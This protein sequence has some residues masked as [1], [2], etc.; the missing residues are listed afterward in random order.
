MQGNW[1]WSAS[2]EKSYSESTVDGWLGIDHVARLATVPTKTA[3]L[4]GICGGSIR[5][6]LIQSTTDHIWNTRQTKRFQTVLLRSSS[7]ITCFP[8]SLIWRRVTVAVDRCSRNNKTKLWSGLLPPKLRR[9]LFF[10]PELRSC[11][12]SSSW[13]GERTPDSQ[14]SMAGT[15]SWR[16]CGNTPETQQRKKEISRQAYIWERRVEEFNWYRSGWRSRWNNVPLWSGAWCASLCWRSFFLTRLQSEGGWEPISQPG[17]CC[18]S[19]SLRSCNTN[20]IKTVSS[21][22]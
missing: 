4:R 21:R 3:C 9:F 2:G 16:K 11:S 13:L 10:V 19:Y 7:S 8:A 15:F 1:L 22:G 5:F 17:Y 12:S 20:N 18:P 6:H 14:P